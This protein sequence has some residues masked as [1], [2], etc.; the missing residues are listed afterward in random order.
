MTPTNP[1][2]PGTFEHGLWET[3]NRAFFQQPVHA[4]ILEVE[5]HLRQHIHEL[6]VLARDADTVP[7]R[8]RLVDSILALELCAEELNEIAEHQ[9]V[10]IVDSNDEPGSE[11]ERLRSS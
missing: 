7:L 11:L 5:H 10:A 1:Y 8:S 2:R 4:Q 6:R 3:W 9:F